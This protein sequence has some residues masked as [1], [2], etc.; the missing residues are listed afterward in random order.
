MGY[1]VLHFNKAKGSSEARMTAHI[2]RKVDPPNADKSRTHLNRE[3]IEFPDGVTNRTQ[4]IQHRIKTAG[5]FR[6]ITSDQV[7]VIRV[8][9]SGSHKDMM[10]IQAE[11][12]IGEWCKDNLDYFKREFGEKNIVS[13]VLHMDEKTP[14][15]H[16]A[17]VPIVTGKRRKAKE[18]AEMK[19][20]N[21]I[22]LCADD[23]LTRTKMKEY[24][25]SYALAMAKYGLKRGEEGSKA[26]H[27]ST[28][29][30][31]RDT[32]VQTQELK[33]EVD[34]L[35]V[36]KEQ[37]QQILMHLQ[38]QEMDGKQ[39]VADLQAEGD[40][41]QKEAEEN[42]R[43]ARKAKNEVAALGIEKILKETGKDLLE[44]IGSA[45]KGNPKAK[46]LEAENNSLKVEIDTLQDEKE[47]IV[48]QSQ[49]E[50]AEKNRSILEK[51]SLIVVQKSERDR[52][53][54][55]FPVLNDYN[56]I[57]RLCDTIKMPANI[58]DKLFADKVVYYTG[59]LYSP[60]HEQF[61]QAENLKISIEKDAKN[62]K[63]FLALGDMYHVEWF[64]RQKQMF[65][66]KLG[67]KVDEQKKQMKQKW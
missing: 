40:K 5:I 15:I 51:N 4:A 6:K 17:L 11:G 52:L 41:K 36:Q 46:K 3:F 16:I 32:F 26:K 23:I 35:M 21:I 66:E 7:R 49:K 65:Y 43:L 8:N 9:V 29:E 20:K 47:N 67:I 63:P 2:E 62:N 54:T 48:R 19:K 61:F 64:R 24:Q 44:S 59:S 38:Q 42:I 14:H 34:E 13:A 56:F 53:F 31:Y 45:L 55:L 37:E 60:E 25:D 30:H 10:R 18:E 22:R 12:R 33:L 58:V 1:V 50:I 39:R 28:L 57:L 27:K